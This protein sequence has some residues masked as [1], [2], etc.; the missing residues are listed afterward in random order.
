MVKLD[1]FYTGFTTCHLNVLLC[2]P[3]ENKMASFQGNELGGKGKS[4]LHL[5]L[6]RL[7][8]WVFKYPPPKC[9]KMILR[10]E[11]CLGKERIAK[12]RVP[13]RKEYCT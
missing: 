1:N 11:V 6:P 3:L 5:M 9:R 7:T 4:I 13:W 8:C 2:I 12:E 10:I